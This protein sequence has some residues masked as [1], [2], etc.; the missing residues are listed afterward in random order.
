MDVIR[1]RLYKRELEANV[2]RVF[3]VSSSSLWNSGRRRLIGMGGSKK[4]AGGR[5]VDVRLTQVQVQFF[6]LLSDHV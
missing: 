5:D 4:R 2:K 3:A 6:S 1:S